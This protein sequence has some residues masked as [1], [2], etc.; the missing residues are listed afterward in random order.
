MK[1]IIEEFKDREKTN[2]E[3]LL[4]LVKK[5]EEIKYLKKENER[6]KSKESLS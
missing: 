6:L 5:D 1:K 4:K 3:L 2:E